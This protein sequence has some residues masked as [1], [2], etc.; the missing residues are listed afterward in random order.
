MLLKLV[1]FALRYNDRCIHGIVVKLHMSCCFPFSVVMTEN[2]R[3]AVAYLCVSGVIVQ[4][5][6][7]VRT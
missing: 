7:S 3:G 6:S 1:V 4:C 2:G 5:S